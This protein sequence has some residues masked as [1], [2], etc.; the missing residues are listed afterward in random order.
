[1]KF[2]D[3]AWEDGRTASTITKALLFRVYQSRVDDAPEF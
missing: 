3:S 2:T 1:M